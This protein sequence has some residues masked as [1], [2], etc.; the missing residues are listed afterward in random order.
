MAKKISWR[1]TA[2]I[3]GVADR[4]MG[5]WRDY[6][7]LA[8]L[9]KGRPASKRV[10]LVPVEEMLRLDLKVYSDLNIRHFHEK[11]GEAN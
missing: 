10:P 6:D 9:R 11:L 2:E 7:G 3:I 5:R 4:T 8:D 1:A